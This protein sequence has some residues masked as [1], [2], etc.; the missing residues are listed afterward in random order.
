MSTSKAV[1]VNEQW[2]SRGQDS[3]SRTVALLRIGRICQRG[4]ARTAMLLHELGANLRGTTNRATRH[5]AARA[6]QSSHSTRRRLLPT[7]ELCETC[8]GD[9][10]CMS[11]RKVLRLAQAPILGP[12]GTHCSAGL[13][14]T[15]P[16]SVD[17]PRLWGLQSQS[18]HCFA[19]R[20]WRRRWGNAGR[21]S[22]V[23]PAQTCGG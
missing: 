21:M 14:L 8:P 18:V 16:Q 7:G 11:L 3:R 23:F 2:D 22:A 17:C 12:Q 1:R 4:S 5:R 13:Y 20:R 10:V 19:T 15:A 6:A 9:N